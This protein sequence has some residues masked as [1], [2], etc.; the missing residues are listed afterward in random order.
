MFSKAALIS[1]LVAVTEARF[2]QE[3][4]PVAAVQALSNRGNPGDSGTLSGQ[5]PGVLL[6]G[7]NACA[8]VRARCQPL[9]IKTVG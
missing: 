7:A 4:T 1:I 3:Q 5:V 2:G 6:A 9:L 8:K